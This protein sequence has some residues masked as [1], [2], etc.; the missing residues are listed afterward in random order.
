M[1]K[2]L[3]VMAALVG[4]QAAAEIPLFQPAQVPHHVYDGGW[5]HFVGGGLA[6][7][8]CDGDARPDMVAAGGSNPPV[9]L[10]NRSPNGGDLSFEKA[11]PD[12]FN[13]NGTV[14][15][16]PVDVDNDGLLDLV[17]LRVG[18]DVILRGLGNCE[19]GPMAFDTGDHWSTAFSATWEAG[20]TMPTL[21]FGH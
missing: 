11:T 21:A 20:Q 16:Y 10:R 2:S 1:R 17:M 19:F 8:D 12:A 4:G 3:C 7:L 14:G 15:A 9:L 6:V 18:P 5:E 13:L